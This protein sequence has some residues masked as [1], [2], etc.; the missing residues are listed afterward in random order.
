MADF[1][2]GGLASNYDVQGIIDNMLKARL[3]PRTRW[4]AEQDEI[5]AD[6][7]A[8][9]DISASMT[10]LTDTLDILRASETWSGMLAGISDTSK[11]SATASSAA[12]AASYRVAIQ[13][14]AQAHSVGSDTAS[15]L[16]VA[17]ASA[18]L[19]GTALTAGD[20]F[21]IGTGADQKTITVD[22]TE[23]LVTLAGKINTAASSMSA[24][25]RVNA[26]I[27]DN[28]L[29]ITRVNTGSTEIAMADVG[30]GTALT[31]LGIIGVAPAFKNQ[32][33]AAQDA[34]FSVNGMPVTRSS[35]TNIT[36]VI[37]GVS[38]NLLNTTTSDVT[39]S[40]GNDTE[41]P[42]TAILNF[43]DAYNV[44][45]AKLKEYGNIEVSGSS[46]KGAVID[47]DSLG[48][49]SNDPLVAEL[50]RN[51]RSQVTSTKYPVLNQINA[52]YSF[53]GRTGI[54]DSLADVG[55]WTSDRTNAISVVDEDRLD[56]AL[57][58]YFSEAEQLFRGI[59]DS[60]E[61]YKDGVASD[62]YKYA[63]K[64]SASMTGM[65]AQRITKLDEKYEDRQDTIDAF[66]TDLK[67]YE[68][69]LWKE[70]T[71]MEETISKLQSK[72]AGL[73]QLQK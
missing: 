28:R 53:E 2:L 60:E 73:Q 7:G 18:D 31:S 50:A 57:E 37:D 20:Q 9:S 47:T 46:V 61:G 32:F 24:A 36:D 1:H 54:M 33:V 21:T 42:K 35:N 14:R 6:V 51:L 30:A 26:V 44:V 12:V 43:I 5:S 41:R 55:V 52:S 10:S 72:L 25:A 71:A 11:L 34:L 49:L 58:N 4:V 59:Y 27:M 68:Q 16:G 39:L 65:I 40:I 23:S 13:Q 17:N 56:N 8:W 69:E 62:F 70:F 22:A 19:V 64:A 45:A 15:T 67:E 66:D 38:L 3:A 48:E 63:D 29:V